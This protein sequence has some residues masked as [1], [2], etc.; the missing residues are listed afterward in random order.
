MLG[1]FFQGLQLSPRSPK[2][3]ERILDS[4]NL[5]DDSELSL[6]QVESDGDF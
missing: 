2:R 5:S 4:G 1:L 6:S 3:M